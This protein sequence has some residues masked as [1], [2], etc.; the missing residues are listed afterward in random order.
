MT[1]LW[2]QE[3]I[4]LALKVIMTLSVDS[5]TTEGRTKSVWSEALIVRWEAPPK[6]ALKDVSDPNGISKVSPMGI[7]A[8]MFAYIQLVD[9][10]E[11]LQD[12]FSSPSSQCEREPLLL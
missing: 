3:F 9:F 1:R 5:S 2:Y 8:L 6:E 4:K 7:G 12:L 11:T 10:M